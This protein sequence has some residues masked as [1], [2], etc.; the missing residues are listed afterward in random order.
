VAKNREY[1][2]PWVNERKRCQRQLSRTV[3]C[4]IVIVSGGKGVSGKAPV[5]FLVA[6]SCRVC[7]Q[8]MSTSDV[9][10]T[11]QVWPNVRLELRHIHGLGERTPCNRRH[12]Q[13][14]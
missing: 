9:S 11:T 14:S 6:R 10:V 5:H 2:H 3:L 4:R 13:L 8:S 12:L 7:Y 1:T